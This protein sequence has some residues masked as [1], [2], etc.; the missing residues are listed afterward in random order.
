MKQISVIVLASIISVSAFASRQDVRDILNLTEQVR[1]ATQSTAAS[2]SDLAEVKEKL[3]EVVALLNQGPA[4]VPTET[5]CFDFAYAKYYVTQTSATA[6]D[7]ALAACKR[8]SDLEVTKFIYEKLYVTLTAANAMDGAT[9]LSEKLGRGRLEMLKFAYEKYYVTMSAKSAIT[10]AAEQVATL[11]RG[12]LE[13]L[14]SLYKK[15]YQTQS[16]AT[17]MDSAVTGCR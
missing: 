13:C 17:A 16:S 10:K 12:R 1:L 14:Q 15:Y 2:E 9:E 8:I 11:G 7:N 3:R 6:T 5:G 4:P